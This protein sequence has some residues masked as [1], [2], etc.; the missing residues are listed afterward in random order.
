MTDSDES[1]MEIH[2][3]DKESAIKKAAEEFIS[4]HSNFLA[5]ISTFLKMDRKRDGIVSA[6][7][8]K[9]YLSSCGVNV[10]DNRIHINDC[11]KMAVKDGIL[12]Q[13]SGK[14]ASGSFKLANQSKAKA[15]K[16]NRRAVKSTLPTTDKPD[17]HIYS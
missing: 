2:S 4:M 9:K 8:I 6:I 17:L 3:E 13:V 15:K 11:L 10:K 1:D 16:S 14:G 5:M 7:A 12:E